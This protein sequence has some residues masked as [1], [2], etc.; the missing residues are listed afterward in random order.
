MNN[1]NTHY[2]LHTETLE[3]CAWRDAVAKADREAAEAFGMLNA[4]VSAGAPRAE[5]RAWQ[6][7]AFAAEAEYN[8]LTN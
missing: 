6:D 1:N 2:P 3:A 5:I 4:L 8:R 7:K